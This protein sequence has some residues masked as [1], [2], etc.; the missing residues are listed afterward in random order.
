LLREVLDGL[1]DGRFSNGDRE[2][3]KPLVDELLNADRYFLLAD[4][5]SYAF[6]QSGIN[7]AFSD[8]YHWSRMSILNTARSGKF[9]SD[10]TIRE[11]C[12]DIWDIPVASS[13]GPI[14]T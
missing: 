2:I 11:Y 13:E 9:S 10:R 7:T 12:R 14:V 6:A 4:F 5:D 8:T 3:F 1:S